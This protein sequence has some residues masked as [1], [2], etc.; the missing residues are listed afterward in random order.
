MREETKLT[1]LTTLAQSPGPPVE[2]MPGPSCWEFA[3][4]EGKHVPLNHKITFLQKGKTNYINSTWVYHDAE[5]C[6][7]YFPAQW[8]LN[9]RPLLLSTSFHRWRRIGNG[10]PAGVRMTFLSLINSKLQASIYMH[11]R[12]A[13]T[14]LARWQEDEVMMSFVWQHRFGIVFTQL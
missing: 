5:C 8:N 11:W 1:W 7:S 6:N 13:P 2:K 14:N 12:T 9:F 10:F 3:I 4:W